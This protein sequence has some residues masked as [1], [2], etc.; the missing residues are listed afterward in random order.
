MMKGGRGVISRSSTVWSPPSEGVIKVNFDA[1]IDEVNQK[2]GIGLIAINHMGEVMFTTCVGRHFVDHVSLVEGYAL[3]RG[4]EICMDLNIKNVVYECDARSVIQATKNCMADCSWLGHV[5]EELK[6][7]L[8]MRK[9]WEVHFIYME[10]NKLLILLQ[11]KLFR[12]MHSRYGLKRA[13]MR[14]MLL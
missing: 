9:E 8:S 13:R 14:L 2:L 3:W 11:R 12:C 7:L 5:V 4:I 6:Y 1:T 10:G